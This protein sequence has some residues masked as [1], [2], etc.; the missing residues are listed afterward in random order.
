MQLLQWENL[1]RQGKKLRLSISIKFIEDSAPSCTRTDKRGNSSTTNGMLRDLHHQVIAED[2]S[3]Q[4]P[5]WRDVYKKM[6]CP[7]PPCHHDGQYCWLDPVGKKHYR[8]RTHHMKALVKYVEQGGILESH[9]DVPDTIRDQLYAEEQHRIDKRQKPSGPTIGSMYPPININVAPTHSF[10]SQDTV[11]DRTETTASGQADID[12][13]G[14]IEEAVEEYTNWHLAKVSTENFKENIWRARDIVLDNCLDL[15]QLHNAKIGA[16][17][18]VKEGVKI[19]VAYRFVSDT[20]KWLSQR[21][22]KAVKEDDDWGI[23]ID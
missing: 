23:L 20:G 6:R 15:G 5:I 19:G 21:K 8:L 22:A 10:Q 14:P 3:G 7:G 9:D 13:P 12:I 11:H 1:C 17:F 2:L 16:E 18:F 4:P